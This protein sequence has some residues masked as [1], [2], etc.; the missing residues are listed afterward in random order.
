MSYALALISL[1]IVSTGLIVLN[2]W[3]KSEAQVYA[4]IGLT[5][6]L[7]TQIFILFTLR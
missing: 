7:I 4:L 6:I 3:V 1:V 5:F 2:K